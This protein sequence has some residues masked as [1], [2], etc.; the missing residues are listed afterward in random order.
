MVPGVENTAISNP[1][2]MAIRIPV[3]QADIFIAIERRHYCLSTI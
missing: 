2:N 1:E 3:A